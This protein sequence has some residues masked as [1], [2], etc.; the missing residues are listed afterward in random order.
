M[1]NV[2]KDMCLGLFADPREADQS[3]DE[4]KAAGFRKEEISLIM[5]EEGRVEPRG[6]GSEIARD[7]AAGVRT[8]GAIGGIAGLIV[9]IA[10][11]T[12]P[13]IGGIII[14]GPLAIALG[15]VQLGTTTLAGAVTGA[16]AGGIIGGLVG[17]G[18]P[19]ERAEV[20]EEA[21]R[22]GQILLAVSVTPENREK[23]TEIFRRHGAGQVCNI[24]PSEK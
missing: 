7:A 19:R 17:L 9:G 4:L 11:I 10:V 3:V 14:A 24:Q 1:A 21:I 5:R 2:T 20:Y 12:V 22:K 16:A 18:L 6:R 13:G 23:A 15:L 8:G